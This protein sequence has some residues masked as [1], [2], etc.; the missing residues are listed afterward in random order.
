MP[1]FCGDERYRKGLRFPARHRFYPDG[2]GPVLYLDKPG[3]PECLF[4]RFALEPE[5][6]DPGIVVM[7][8][9]VVRVEIRNR[10]QAPR[11]ECFKKLCKEWRDILYVVKGHAADNQ[12]IPAGNV[13]APVEID[14]AALHVL[15]FS[16]LDFF[17]EDGEHSLR[18]VDAGDGADMGLEMKC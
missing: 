1:V 6:E 15:Q 17:V 7:E 8:L 10:N 9:P 2:S 11:E 14:V 3:I 16:V 18:T 12:V 13:V 4:L 5:V